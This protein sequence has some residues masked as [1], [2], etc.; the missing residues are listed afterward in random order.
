MKNKLSGL[1]FSNRSATLCRGLPVSWVWLS[2]SVLYG[3]HPED[4]DAFRPNFQPLYESSFEHAL[5]WADQS[6]GFAALHLFT[7]PCANPQYVSFL[8]H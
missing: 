3:K 2:L 7:A 6:P 1:K 8:R 5:A 4:G